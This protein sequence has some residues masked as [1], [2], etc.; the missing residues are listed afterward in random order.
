ML[1][2]HRAIKDNWI[3]LNVTGILQHL[4]VEQT[5]NTT[6]PQSWQIIVGK[7][8]NKMLCAPEPDMWTY[9]PVQVNCTTCT[10]SADVPSVFG[11]D[12]KH[13]AVVHIRHA[14]ITGTRRRRRNSN[15]QQRQ[16]CPPISKSTQQVCV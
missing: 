9:T 11:V 5:D 3:A 12:G 2:E 15:S 7:L 6:H 8:C 16:P 10:P 4:I 13:T 14:P 1:F